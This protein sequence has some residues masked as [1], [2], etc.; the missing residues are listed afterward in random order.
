MKSDKKTEKSEE[1]EININEEYEV[2]YWSSRLR[3]SQK[4]LKQTLESIGSN[5]IYDIEEYLKSHQ[6]KHSS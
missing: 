4:Q 1:I 3:V 5:Y 2:Q 6:K